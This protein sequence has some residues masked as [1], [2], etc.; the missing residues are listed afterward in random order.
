MRVYFG[1]ERFKIHRFH[2]NMSH[3]VELGGTRPP[4]ESSISGIQ[5][6]FLELSL[7]QKDTLALRGRG[8]LFTQF[9]RDY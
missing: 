8:N 7:T 1:I 6:D 5:L 3:P 4:R 2:W 9:L